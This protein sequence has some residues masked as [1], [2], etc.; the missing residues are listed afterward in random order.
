MPYMSGR[1]WTTS[2]LSLVFPKPIQ[3][4]RGAT[5]V[6][7]QTYIGLHRGQLFNFKTVFAENG[8]LACVF[9]EGTSDF[10]LFD[11]RTE[12]SYPRHSHHDANG[13]PIPRDR[14]VER[15]RILR[16]ENPGTPQV[17]GFEVRE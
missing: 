8:Q 13:R 3:I 6:V 4:T 2:R 1:I 7:P 17:P 11:L 5:V 16:R 15:F 14:W 10:L 9:S 12:E